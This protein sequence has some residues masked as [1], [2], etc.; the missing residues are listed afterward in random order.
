MDQA[1]LRVP[2]GSLHKEAMDVCSLSRGA[3]EVFPVLLGDVTL[4]AHAIQRPLI[5]ASHGL[6]DGCQ[7]G[8]RVE[9]A[10]QPD[11]RRHVEVG[12]PVLK[13]SY[14]EQEIS[15]P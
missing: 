5:L 2:A 10:G 13:V 14:A 3:A 15:V 6:H 9:E 7:E 1:G 12:D 11:T 4:Q 8:L